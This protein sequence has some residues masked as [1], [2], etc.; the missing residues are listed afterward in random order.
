MDS[1]ER[2]MNPVAMPIINPVLQ[3]L[4]PRYSDFENIH[5]RKK[6]INPCSNDTNLGPHQ[7]D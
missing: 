1:G 6:G 3:G 4:G 5:L 2:G 7:T